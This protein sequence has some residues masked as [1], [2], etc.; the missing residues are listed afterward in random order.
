V[1]ECW[2][3]CVSDSTP[4]HHVPKLVEQRLHLVVC[5]PAPVEIRDQGADRLRFTLRLTA[6]TART[7]IC[8]G[9]YLDLYAAEVRRAAPR[10]QPQSESQTDQRP[11]R[12]SR[13]ARLTH[14]EMET[15]LHEFGHVM[16]GV[17]SETQYNQHSGTNVERDFVEAPSQMYEEWGSRLESLS[18]LRD[19]LPTCRRR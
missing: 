3:Y 13:P 15:L 4:W 19:P 10:R 9:I 14:D 18:M 7:L 1:P 8:R 11:G 17:L 5:Q 12:E 16:H 6:G 2:L